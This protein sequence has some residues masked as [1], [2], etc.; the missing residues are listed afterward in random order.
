[1]ADEQ[2]MRIGEVAAD[3]RVNIRTLRFYEREGV[4]PPPDRTQ[5]GYR[6]YP[7]QTVGLLRFIKRA[8]SLGYTLREVKELLAL[9]EAGN[10]SCE[11]VQR[12]ASAKLDDVKGRIRQLE[13]MARALSE[14]ISSCSNPHHAHCC[15]LLEALDAPDTNVLGRDDSRPSDPNEKSQHV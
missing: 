7:P 5:S 6:I 8:Q 2:G 10:A 14:L 11:E 12:S 1:M 3:A 4:L 13:S 9:R 15:P